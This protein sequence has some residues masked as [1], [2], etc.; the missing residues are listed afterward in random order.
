MRKLAILVTIVFALTPTR[1]RAQDAQQSG[2]AF[3][4]RCAIFL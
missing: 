4:A 3:R 2:Q 1:D